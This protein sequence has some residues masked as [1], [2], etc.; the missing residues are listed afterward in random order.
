MSDEPV[1]ADF[2]HTPCCGWC[3]GECPGCCACGTRGCSGCQRGDEVDLATGSVVDTRG[4]PIVGE[5]GCT[6][7]VP[8]RPPIDGRVSVQF[9]T[10]PP[11]LGRLLDALRA[12]E[13]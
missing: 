10:S 3:L 8:P 9:D 6:L 11:T 2:A 4:W 13:Q 1:P 12:E 7:F 5:E